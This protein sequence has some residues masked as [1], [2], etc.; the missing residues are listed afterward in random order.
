MNTKCLHPPPKKHIV[1]G[2]ET[3]CDETAVA[4]VTS[5]REI[6]SNVVYTQLHEHKDYGGV[7]P[8]I[9]ARS[10]LEKCTMVIQ[11]ALTDAQIKMRDITAV[12]AATGPGL[13]GGLL[14]GM[15]MAKGI[16]WAND[17]PFISINHLE[18]HALTARLT[19]DVSFPFLLLLVSGGHTQI[20]QVNG[21][22]QY[23]ILG[24][25]LDDAV[26]EA[27]DKTANILGVGYP[28]GVALEKRA[29]Q[30][31]IGHITL[32]VP[33]RGKQNC[34]FSLSG[35]K[36]R[37]RQLLEQQKPHITETYISNMC[38]EFQH[39]VA[40]SL[41]NRILRAFDIFRTKTKTENPDFVMAGGVASN[42]YIRTMLRD[43]ATQHNFNFKV[44]PVHLCTDNGAM[45]AWAGIE[46]LTLN[47]PI[48]GGMDT[49][50]QPRWGLQDLTT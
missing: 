34:D 45:I 14:V 24:E 5:D 7:V 38:A 16:A 39:A 23:D 48:L 37:V 13:V 31:E 15:Q 12:C 10:H 29:T 9:A 1:L 47:P 32:P 6:L 3:S 27:F 19:S 36:T 50:A 43:C 33:M 8:E 49:P 22:G 28:G 46:R 30:G 4:V 40:L 42:T 26:G 11:Q 41:Q 20:L 18:A 2:I 25:T 21:V 35:L 44:A 17:I